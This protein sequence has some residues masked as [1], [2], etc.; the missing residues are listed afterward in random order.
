MS[1]FEEIEGDDGD[2]DDDDDSVMLSTQN[3]N[4]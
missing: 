1:D 4:N 2:D 3:S